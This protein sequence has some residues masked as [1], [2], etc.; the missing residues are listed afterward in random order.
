MCDVASQVRLV[1]PKASLS[2]VAL[3]RLGDVG[4]DF[5]LEVS[6]LEAEVGI[7]ADKSFTQGHKAANVHDIIRGEVMQLK[8]VK[9]HESSKERMYQKSKVAEEEGHEANSL[10]L[11]RHRDDFGYLP[12]FGHHHRR[13]AVRDPRRRQVPLLE[14]WWR[15]AAV[16]VEAIHFPLVL[17]ATFGFPLPPSAASLP[18]ARQDNPTH[19]PLTRG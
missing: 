1:Y 18:A 14:R 7:N 10:V 2:K 15:C 9:V 3:A 4:L 13:A 17:D 12:F 19:F 11:S 6:S 8:P 16:T 5:H